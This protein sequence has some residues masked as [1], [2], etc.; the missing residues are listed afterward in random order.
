[1]FNTNSYLKQAKSTFTPTGIVNL[2]I[3]Y[4]VT[5]WPHD[6]GAEF[7]TGNFY[8]ELTKNP[9]VEK[10]GY[11]GYGIGFDACSSFSLSND[12]GFG[13]NVIILGLDNSSFIH[14]DNKKK[15]SNSWENFNRWVR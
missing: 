9:D 3:V 11:S 13:Q 7:T 5:L 4:E 8:L 2:Y 12:S 6:L 15:N 14:A 1:M 10:Y